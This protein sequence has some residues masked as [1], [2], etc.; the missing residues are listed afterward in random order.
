MHF[1]R[2]LSTACTVL[3]CAGIVSAQEQGMLTRAEWSKRVGDAAKS[4][5]TLAETIKLVAPDERV[6]F[7][8]KVLKAITKMPLDSNTKATRYVEGSIHCVYNTSLQDDSKYGAIAESIALSPVPILPAL[9]K[10]L[11]K[12]FD[13]SLNVNNLTDERYREIAEKGVQTC[14]ERNASEDDPKIRNT[15]AI[16]L[17][18]RSAQNTASLQE[19]LLA[20]LPNARDRELAATWL[21]DAAKDDYTAILAAADVQVY[22]PP[23]AISMVGYSQTARLLA[24]M[25]LTDSMFEAI[26][27]HSTGSGLGE[28]DLQID[29][30]FQQTPKEKAPVGYQNQGTSLTR[31][32]W[33][34]EVLE[35]IERKRTP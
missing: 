3:F 30:G 20:K 9:V 32:C 15:F 8:R 19:V 17:F 14:I 27:R 35:V 25:V 31:P 10:E 33:C 7:S 26:M 5:V 13:P 24:D 21:A 2:I 16:L 22:P 29:S 11:S 23:P 1:T 28:I 34:L 6:E 12:R 18:T 4:A